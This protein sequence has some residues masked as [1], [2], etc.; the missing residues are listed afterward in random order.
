VLLDATV[1]RMVLV[2]AF[3]QAMGRWNWCPGNRGMV[4]EQRKARR[5]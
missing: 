1:I 3:M 2:P 5:G 4:R